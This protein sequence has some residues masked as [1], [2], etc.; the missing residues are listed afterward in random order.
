[1]G[2]TPERWADL[3]AEIQRRLR[4]AFEKAMDDEAHRLVA[5]ETAPGE[6][7]SFFRLVSPPEA[8]GS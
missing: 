8:D 5:V 6:L 3:E 4:L 2:M 7:G 1:M